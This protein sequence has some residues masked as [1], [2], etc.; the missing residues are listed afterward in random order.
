MLP[1][2]PQM[3]DCSEGD[4]EKG[5]GWIRVIRYHKIHKPHSVAAD[6]PQAA[7][8]RP[9]DLSSCSRKPLPDESPQ[10][11]EENGRER[12]WAAGWVCWSQRTFLGLLTHFGVFLTF[13]LSVWD[14][15]N[16]SRLFTPQEGLDSR[17]TKQCFTAEPVEVKGE[18]KH[19][20][21]RP[22]AV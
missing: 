9:F 19:C 17:S 6:W 1:L 14:H 21:K 12:S 8:I 16:V 7:V 5:S 10:T 2:E 13:S 3:S 15:F 22:E 11:K 20:W 18:T 4:T